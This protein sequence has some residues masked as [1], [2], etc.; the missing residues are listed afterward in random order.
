MVQETLQAYIPEAPAATSIWSRQY[1]A[2]TIGLILTVAGSA[3]EALAVATTMP[4]TARELG[5]LA[6]YGWAF[7]AFML[8]NLIGITVAGGEADRQGTARP[9]LVGV[10][11]FVLGLLMGGLAPTMMVLIAGRA[12]QGFGAGFISSTAYIAIGRGYP[13]SAKPRMLAVISSAWVVPGLVGPALA[14]MVA[15]HLGWRW[16]FL[17]L[18]PLPAIAAALAW[19][20]LQRFSQGSDTPRDWERIRSAARLAAGTGLLVTGLGTPSPLIAAALVG[21]GTALGLPA[22][23]RLLPQGTLRASGGLPAAIATNGLLSLAFF[24]A[25]AFV[26]LAL[27]AVRGQSATAAGL[28]LTAATLSWTTGAWLLAHFAARQGRR[29]IVVAGLVLTAVG[30]AGVAGVLAPAV[31]AWL[32]LA[33]WAVAG[34]GVGLAFS[35]LTLVVLEMAPAGQEGAATSAMQLANVLGVALGTGL[36]G[37]IVAY[38]SAGG[39]QPTIGILGQ[40]LLMIGVLALAV[41]TASRLPGGR[42]PTAAARA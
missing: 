2:L 34:L 40:D 21:A 31:P 1:R 26:P 38:A 30:I 14:G 33:A 6:L 23:R 24:G 22:L 41:L 35:A 17:G 10:A 19:P 12:V 36:G 8:S 4:A 28:A 5:G 13:E 25:D 37:V 42:E 20:A 27:T 11:L 39:G 3:F 29:L 18:A 7:S 9:F 32:A 16:V 15:D